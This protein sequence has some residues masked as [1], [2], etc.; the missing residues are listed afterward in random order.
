LVYKPL[1]VGPARPLALVQPLL[2]LVVTTGLF[3]RL[4]QVTH[5]RR[6]GGQQQAKKKE[7][8]HE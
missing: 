5:G 6:A 7:R 1:V 3:G 2:V 4:G 8:F